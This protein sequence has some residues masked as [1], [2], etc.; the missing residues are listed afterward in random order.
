MIKATS[1]KIRISRYEFSIWK[2]SVILGSFK[3]LTLIFFSVNSNGNCIYLR[4][5]LWRLNKMTH[6]KIWHTEDI[7]NINK[8]LKSFMKTLST[9]LLHS[10][11]S[12]MNFSFCWENERIFDLT[13][14][15]NIFEYKNRISLL[16][17]LLAVG[18]YF[19]CS[20]YRSFKGNGSCF[21]SQSPFLLPNIIVF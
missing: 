2:N 1:F 17:Q 9:S 12:V 10:E 5:L 8:Y 14:Q 16:T 19:L 13:H 20:E 15:I 6:A 21:N 4:V 7:L 3:T 11:F 18:A